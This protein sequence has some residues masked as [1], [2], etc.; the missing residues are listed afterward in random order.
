MQ[1][2]DAE[3]IAALDRHGIAL[4]E[5]A[6]VSR[7]DLLDLLATQAIDAIG[8]GRTFIT[9]YPADQ[10]ALARIVTDAEG[11]EVAAR[12]ELVVDGIEIA[13]G[14]DEL[15]DAQVLQ[16][17]MLADSV[18]R[19]RTGREIPAA[20][21]RLLAAM[22]HGLPGCSGVAL[23]FDRLLMLKL[24]VERIDQVLPFSFVRA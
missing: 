23:G 13:N 18:V 8:A 11:F 21:A 16:R 12:F 14:Y 24:G 7:R 20:D 3:L 5:N 6:G 15:A 19:E 22:R 1:C 9:H 10:A 4:S 2:A 17:R